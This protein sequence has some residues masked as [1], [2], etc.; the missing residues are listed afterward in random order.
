[1]T[2]L[3]RNNITSALAGIGAAGLIAQEG[4]DR[5]PGSS[6]E[7]ALAIG[8]GPA[9]VLVIYGLV[10]ARKSAGKEAEEEGTDQQEGWKPEYPAAVLGFAAVFVLRAVAGFAP[11]VLLGSP[12]FGWERGGQVAVLSVPVLNNGDF[13]VHLERIIVD[14][15]SGSAG[16]CFPPLSDRVDYALIDSVTIAEFDLRGVQGT[17]PI[18]SLLDSIQPIRVATVSVEGTTRAECPLS[19]VELSVPVDAI[20]GDNGLMFQLHI[21][22][23]FRII[24][25]DSSLAKRHRLIPTLREDTVQMAIYGFDSNLHR[26]LDSTR[27]V[28]T[29]TWYPPMSGS[30]ST[31]GRSTLIILTAETNVGPSRPVTLADPWY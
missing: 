1:M 21:P 7:L 4:L 25:S 24:E 13:P 3:L 30:P 29:L 16:A 10:R 28:D 22:T 6:P 23:E 11:Q 20:V 8:L 15:Q 26:L 12:S 17:L 2:R 14:V 19:R 18:E 5:F 9:L 31:N 27:W